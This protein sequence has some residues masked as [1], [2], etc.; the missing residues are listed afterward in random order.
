MSQSKVRSWG[1]GKVVSVGEGGAE[2]GEDT[3][4]EEEE[5]G[6]GGMTSVAELERADDEADRDELEEGSGKRVSTPIVLVAAAVSVRA[7]EL[8][9]DS[10]SSVA[11][12]VAE[13]VSRSVMAGIEIPASTD[14]EK[15]TPGPSV[16]AV[17]LDKTGSS[18]SVAPGVEIFPSTDSVNVGKMPVSTVVLVV[19]VDPM[20]SVKTSVLEIG[21]SMVSDL[22]NVIAVGTSIVSVLVKVTAVSVTMGEETGISIVSVL[23]KVTAVSVAAEDGKGISMV[24]V[25]VKVIDVGTSMVSVLVKVIAVGTSTVSLLP[26]VMAV[27]V[28]ETGST[29]SVG[30][31]IRSVIGVVSDGNAGPTVSLMV[32][33]GPKVDSVGSRV[34]SEPGTSTV[35]LLVV[36]AVPVD[37]VEEAGSTESVGSGIRSVDMV[38]SEGNAGATLSLMVKDGPSDVGSVGSNVEDSSEGLVSV[39]AVEV[40]SA[41]SVNV[42]EELG[43]DDSVDDSMPLRSD[44]VV[45]GTVEVA[46]TV[47]VNVNDESVD[48]GRVE[49]SI[50]LRS[51][52]IVRGAVEVPGLEG[53]PGSTE[54]EKVGKKV[55]SVA[56]VESVK[57]NVG[58]TESVSVKLMVGLVVSLSVV[59]GSGSSLSTGALVSAGESH[60]PP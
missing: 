23:V 54:S 8:E 16:T 53:N 36:M 42:N 47:S 49:D 20:V 50:S 12:I 25:L 24:S 9:G 43:D 1:S 34:D 6:G 2:E 4:T 18:V 38:I 39:G 10:V 5:E 45:S 29:E 60:E 57:E 14:S 35:S 59:V 56:M 52:E 58:S 17:E 15:V 26:D 11:G 48:A 33:D 51:E 22:V 19:S 46:S 41:V 30:S 13:S 21:T 3:A 31:G 55:G 40:A 44:G 7:K 32:K 37:P 27:S 28:E